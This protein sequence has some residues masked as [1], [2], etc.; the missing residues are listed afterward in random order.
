MP[1]TKSSPYF[2]TL[3]AEILALGGGFNAHIHIDRAG[4]YD[5]TV[6]LLRDRGVRDGA[7]FTLAGKHSLIP[8]VHASSLYDRDSL[9]DRVSFYLDA[10]VEFGTRRADSVVDVTLD[11][12]GTTALD[13][14]AELRAQYAGRIDF[15]LGAY[16]PLGFRDDEPERWA[17]LE[18][19]AER[20]DFVGLL[21]ERDDKNN[22]P[23]HIGFEE[24]CR[25]GIGL[26]ARLDKDLHIHVD[27]ANHP[28]EDG[29]ELVARA[30]R[31]MGLGRAEG[32][33]PFVWLIHLIS[34]STYDEPRFGDLAEHLAELGIGVI[35]C[36]S[37]AISMRQLRPILSPTNNCIARVLD[38]LDHGVQVR[39]GSDNICDITSHMGTPD[40]LEEV[41]VLANAMRIYDI[42]ILAK[43]A[44]GVP[45]DGED[46]E[47]LRQHLKE[48]AAAVA[49]LMKLQPQLRRV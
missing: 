43:I 19:A 23:D 45:L 9:I 8:M 37:A 20:A 35:C 40:L 49:D 16:S 48:D 44:A 42:G 11:R 34:P 38:L 32:E 4:T 10:M 27:Q 14:L 2:E 47:R 30:V 41:F 31:D 39:I 46:R 7:N 24:S 6:R 28:L 15:R 25:R 21:P 1:R 22:Y 13:T 12:V 17:L 3:N 29:G 36:P 26:A 33:T 5:E 18:R